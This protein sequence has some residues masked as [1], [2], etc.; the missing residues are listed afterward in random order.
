MEKIKPAELTGF[1]CRSISFPVSLYSRRLER[2]VNK[3]VA[4]LK[5]H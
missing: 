1:L 2:I 4:E 5:A 3:L